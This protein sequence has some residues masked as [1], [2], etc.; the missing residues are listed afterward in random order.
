MTS[1][2]LRGLGV[3][4]ASIGETL[5]SHQLVQMRDEALARLRGGELAADR[6]FRKG[7]REDEQKFQAGEGAKNRAAMADSAKNQGRWQPIYEEQVAHDPNTGQATTVRRQV[8]TFNELTNEHRYY[9]PEDFEPAPA[10][11]APAPAAPAAAGPSKGGMGSAAAPAGKRWNDM[12][13][14]EQAKV[15]GDEHV[16]NTVQGWMF[17]P[18]RGLLEAESSGP[19]PPPRGNL[20]YR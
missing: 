13:P 10:P 8:G 9:K 4:L 6:E 2:A 19:R 7:E 17:E 15:R 3:G 14:A 11:A 12:T 5:L 20:Q 16:R 1:R 18:V